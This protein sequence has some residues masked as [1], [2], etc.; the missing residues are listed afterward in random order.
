MPCTRARRAAGPVRSHRRRRRVKLRHGPCLLR[1]VNAGRMRRPQERENPRKNCGVVEDADVPSNWDCRCR[2]AGARAVH[3]FCGCAGQGQGR[4]IPDQ[5][6][7]PVFRRDRER[8]LQGPQRR[9]GDH[10]TDGRPIKRGRVDDQPDRGVGGAGHARRTQ[11]RRQETR[12]RDV[13]RD[14]Q[15]ELPSTRWSSSSSARGCSTR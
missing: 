4:R 5:F 6:L 14:A 15:P 13:H 7:A 2:F 10:Q 1:Q 9:A 8:L 11:R 12:G 3:Q